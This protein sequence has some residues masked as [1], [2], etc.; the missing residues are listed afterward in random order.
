M[1]KICIFVGTT[2]GSYGGWYLGDVLGWGLGGAFIVSG[3]GSVL[4]VYL[5]WKL[6]KKLEE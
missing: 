4:G 2:I 6:A 3:V 5:G 1:T